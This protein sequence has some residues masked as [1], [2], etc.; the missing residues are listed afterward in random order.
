MDFSG[1]F[2]EGP[3]FSKNGRRNYYDE[4]LSLL[5]HFYC[6]NFSCGVNGY[7]VKLDHDPLTPFSMLRLMISNV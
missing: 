1:L 7:L 3:F 6:A 2:P 5:R 4:I